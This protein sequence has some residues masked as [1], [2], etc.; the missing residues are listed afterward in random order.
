MNIEYYARTERVLTSM[1]FT[2]RTSK[3]GIPPPFLFLIKVQYINDL[4]HGF[5]ACRMPEV[6]MVKYEC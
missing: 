5:F 4:A 1:Y 2:F 3:Q 6:A